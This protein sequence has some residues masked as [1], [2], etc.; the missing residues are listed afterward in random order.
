MRRHFLDEADGRRAAQ[1]ARRDAAAERRMSRFQRGVHDLRSVER[2]QRCLGPA[3]VFLARER[4]MRGRKQLQ[5]LLPPAFLV[6]AGELPEPLPDR[7]LDDFTGIAHRAI[8]ASIAPTARPYLK[9]DDAPCFGIACARSIKRADWLVPI[10]EVADG[11]DI[12][13]F[14]GAGADR[15]ECRSPRPAAGRRRPRRRRRPIRR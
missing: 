8:A 2:D 4:R 12:D 15:P 10:D 7:R 3:M 5:G 9:P 1:N 11:G 6:F 14:F 13:A